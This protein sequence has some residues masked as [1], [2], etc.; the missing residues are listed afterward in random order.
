VESPLT[1]ETAEAV[2]AG[3]RHEALAC[4]ARCLEL[5][6]YRRE[7][8]RS[9]SA[10]PDFEL[11]LN[12]GEGIPLLVQSRGDAG[13]IG[14]HWFAIDRSILAQAGIVLLGPPA[15]EVFAPIPLRNLLPVV[16]ASVRWHREHATEPS[17]AVLNACRALRYAA[18]ARWSSKP[19][20]GRWAVEHRLVPADLV[21]RALAARTE[22][23]PLHAPDVDTFLD[24]A[25]TRLRENSA[26]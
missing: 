12:T 9:G 17:D 1:P 26:G 24:A 14:S 10:A 11:N 18:E 2:V 21:T 19:T 22:G 20:A 23:R 15:G 5:V 6:V 13:A 25:E 7:T 16:G 4:P 8:A 3:L